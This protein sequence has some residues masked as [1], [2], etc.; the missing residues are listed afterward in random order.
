MSIS[1][2]TG[3]PSRGEPISHSLKRSFKF[4]VRASRILSFEGSHNLMRI[5]HFVQ[6]RLSMRLVKPPLKIFHVPWRILCLVIFAKW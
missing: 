6:D 2:T 3:K 5:L 4:K 1:P